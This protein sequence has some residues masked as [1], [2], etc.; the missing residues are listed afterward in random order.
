[1]TWVDSAA[2]VLVDVQMAF[3]H[4]RWGR[5]DNPACDDNITALVAAFAAAQVPLVFVRHTSPKTESDFHVDRPGYE[6][7]PYLAGYQPDLTVTK[8]VNSSF[9]GSPS[10][11]AWLRSAGITT[12]V[13]AGI[14]TNHCCETTARVGGNLGFDVR[15]VIDATHTFD[16]V[17]PDGTLMTAAEL[18]RATATNLHGE[19]ATVTTTA[20]VLD[21]LATR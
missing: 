8:T 13:L 9:H 4:P 21:E 18:S 15:F 10:L 5:R 7:K 17:G 19:F 2:L 6:L 11:E 16:R 3:E 20:Q 1:M 12:V 14:T